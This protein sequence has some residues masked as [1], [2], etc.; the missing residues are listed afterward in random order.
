M[1]VL[2]PWFV[3]E[4]FPLV[5]F[6]LV[7]VYLVKEVL[8]VPKDLEFSALEEPLEIGDPGH[9]VLF[10]RADVYSPTLQRLKNLLA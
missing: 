10:G 5:H 2:L 4:L 6:P 1:V 3:Q 8:E 7:A 9:D